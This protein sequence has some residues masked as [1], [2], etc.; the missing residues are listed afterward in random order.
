MNFAAESHVD[1]SLDGPNLF[2]KTNVLGT[3]VVLENAMRCGIRKVVHV[4]TDEVYGDV[5]FGSVSEGAALMPRNPYAASKAGADEMAMA[6]HTTFGLNLCITRSSNNYGVWQHPEKFIAKSILLA[7]QGQPIQF[8]GDGLHMRDWIWV[9]DNC[10]GI[11]VALH[12]GLAGDVYNISSGELY[13]NCTVATSILQIMGLDPGLIEY[14]EDRQ[15]NDRRYSMN[16]TKIRSLGWSPT[17]RLLDGLTETVRWYG[18][19]CDWWQRSI[20]YGCSDPQR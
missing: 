9:L 8:H 16:T 4:S 5:S 14:V 19:T 1:R 10:K 15:A 12:K 18:E 11:D 17:V 13:T 2:V 3:S 20:V 6:Y 7:L